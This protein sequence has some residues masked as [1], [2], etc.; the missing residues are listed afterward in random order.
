MIRSAVW[1]CPGTERPSD[2]CSGL[3]PMPHPTSP[4][5]MLIRWLQF[6]VGG[7]L[8]T[9]GGAAQEADRLLGVDPGPCLM[10]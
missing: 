5:P 1:A 2:P 4:N 9:D 7:D 3:V 6:P 8:G 10:A